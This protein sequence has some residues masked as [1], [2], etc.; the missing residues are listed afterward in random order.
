MVANDVGITAT[1]GTWVAQDFYDQGLG[2]DA[3]YQLAAVDD[4]EVVGYTRAL[5]AM[6][7]VDRD[8][9]WAVRGIKP[10]TLVQYARLTTLASEGENVR[11]GLYKEDASLDVEWKVLQKDR[12]VAIIEHYQE[13][14]E[15][16]GML[17]GI[18][19]SLF[20]EA[21]PP[22]FVLRDLAS[23]ELIRCVFRPSTYPDVY[24]ALERKNGVV[25]IS[26][27]TKA[28]RIDRRVDE[29]RVERLQATPPLNV[30]ELEEFFG[31][32][33]GWTG[34]LTSDEFI[35]QVRNDSEDG[36]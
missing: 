6:S 23:N 20:K 19:H 2:F 28:R 5:D 25:L 27:R 10:T 33:P 7:S 15:Y 13:W 26:G 9:N 31:S 14:I 21:S 34:D 35:K 8:S 36:E 11:L 17:Q 4:P 22:Y 24:K 29:M 32:A 3:E 18:I 16:R 12:A 30:A 1:G